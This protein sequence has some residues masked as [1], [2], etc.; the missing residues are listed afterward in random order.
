MGVVGCPAAARGAT[1]CW[2]AL[3]AGRRLDRAR[4]SVRKMPAIRIPRAW[5]IP[6]SQVTDEAFYLGR[7]WFLKAAGMAGL[8]AIAAASGCSGAASQQGSLPA[9][10]VIPAAWK[11]LY[12]ARRSDR[13]RLDRPLTDEAVAARYNNFYEFTTDKELV[14]K[15]SEKFPFHPWQVEVTGMV[16]KPKT[17]DIDELVKALPLEER[18]YRHRCVEAWAMAVPWTGFPFKVLI[19][20]VEPLSSARYVRL[21]S[22]MK[23]ELA[24]GQ[25]LQSWYP[26]PYYE[27]LTMAEAT[28]ELAM[29]ATGIYGHPLP[30][31]HG[32]PIRLVTPWKYGFKSIK[33]IVKIEFVDKQPPNFWNDVAPTEYDF[34]ANVNP[35]IPH[36]RWSQATERL[37]DTGERVP[38]QLYNGYGEQVAHLYT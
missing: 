29:L 14:G 12:P 20:R 18:L 34:F 9:S 35:A 19:D 5:E 30:M 23:P 7:R 21:V 22:F 27:G 36:P 24:P 2:R 32:A 6:E 33:S 4:R 17:Y 15:I 26:W 37:I 38:T 10:V 31:Q 13:H 11:G 25:A 8:G 3:R 1:V 28:N 16:R